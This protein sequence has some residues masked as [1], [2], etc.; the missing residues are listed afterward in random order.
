MLD[1]SDRNYPAGFPSPLTI[2]FTPARNITVYFRLA[3]GMKKK[4]AHLEIRDVYPII[5]VIIILE[6]GQ[7]S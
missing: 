1:V 7:S 3:D 6:I 4:I 5:I 2:C